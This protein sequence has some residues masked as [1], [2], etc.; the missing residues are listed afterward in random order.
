MESREFFEKV[1]ALGLPGGDYAVFG[2]GP[3][4]ARGLIGH[5]N[6]VDLIARGLAWERAS[7]L[8][9]VEIAP[10]GDPVVKLEGAIDVFVGWLGLD[11]DAVIDRAE[12]VADLP[13]ARLEDVLAF[14][15]ALGR[16]K[17]LRHIRL[18]EEFLRRTS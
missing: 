14:K 5:A 11:V 12:L 3:L 13:F 17:D 9:T 16:P 15:R 18:V 2:S 7:S 10:K 8:G 1:R 6:D 4:V